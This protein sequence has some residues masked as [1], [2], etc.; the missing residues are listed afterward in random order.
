MSAILRRSTAPGP[1]DTRPS[2]QGERTGGGRVRSSVFRRG[3]PGRCGPARRTL[4][5]RREG[6]DGGTDETV[7]RPRRPPLRGEIPPTPPE[8]I[9]RQR[10]ARR[11]LPGRPEL[12]PHDGRP[13]APCSPNGRGP[14]EVIA[15]RTPM[16]R[17]PISRRL[18]PQTVIELGSL[19]LTAAESL[20]L[21]SHLPRALRPTDVGSGSTASPN[22]PALTDRA[23]G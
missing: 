15:P 6:S 3:A 16:H 22:N 8:T 12:P 21:A 4:A 13:R 5:G 10:P 9:G 11:Q 18:K 2:L 14:G 7:P 17:R 1:G 20:W 19:E 23:R